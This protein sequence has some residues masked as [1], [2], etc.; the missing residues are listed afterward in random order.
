MVADAFHD[1]ARAGV[2]HAEALPSGAAQEDLAAGGAVPDDIARD[3]IALGDQ[4]RRDRRPD[5]D[6]PAGQAFP[7]V[8]VRLAEQPQADARREE[9]AEGLA[10]LAREVDGDRVLGQPGV[11]GLGDLVAC[12]LYTSRCV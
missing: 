3:D 4:A 2:A 9:R 1:R 5:R 12:L 11:V 6:A 10:G 7:D 8:V